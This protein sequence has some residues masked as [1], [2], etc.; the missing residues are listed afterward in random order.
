[1]AKDYVAI[2]QRV[3]Y[4][5]IWLRATSLYGNWLRRYMATGYVAIWQRAT[6]QQG[7]DMLRRYMATGYVAIR[8]RQYVAIKLRTTSLYGSGLRRFM[9]TGYVAIRLR[10]TYIAI[11]WVRA[12]HLILYRLLNVFLKFITT[13]LYENWVSMY[14]E[15]NW[16]WLILMMMT[17]IL[18]EIIEFQ[19]V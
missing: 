11:R 16:F 15:F 18:K 14:S 7:Y 5:A 10:A 19:V 9:V 2:W 12:I 17:V 8:L 13:F 1:M 3:S 6:S 4:V